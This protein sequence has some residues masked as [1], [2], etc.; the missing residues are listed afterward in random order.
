LAEIIE[1]IVED[2]IAGKPHSR[3]SEKIPYYII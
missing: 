1:E 2:G 3:C